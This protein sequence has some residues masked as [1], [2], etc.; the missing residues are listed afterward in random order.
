MSEQQTNTNV[1]E[2]TQYHVDELLDALCA[3]FGDDFSRDQVETMLNDSLE[4]LAGQAAV[5]DFLPVLA[6]RYTRERLKSL[7][8]WDERAAGTWDVVFVSLSGGG[9]GQLAAA[10]TTALSG[11]AVSVHAA[12]SQVGAGV[13]PAVAQSLEEVGIDVSDAYARPVSA[14]VLRG[15]DVIVSMGRSVGAFEVPEGTARRVD[16][17]VGDPL[18]ADL[19]EVRRVRDD[20]ERRVRALLDELGCPAAELRRA[21]GHLTGE[22]DTRAVAGSRRAAP[23]A[24]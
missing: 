3:E 14:E 18:G 22:R 5:E 12:G 6:H 24:W 7:L 19:A 4:R 10:L 9:R 11:G 13:D 1:S 17:R 2:V 8:R 20:V 21:D 16:W 15:A 23:L